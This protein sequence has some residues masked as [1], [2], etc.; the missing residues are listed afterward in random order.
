MMKDTGSRGDSIGM[1]K[2]DTGKNNLS[3]GTVVPE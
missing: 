1:E 2:S 3:K